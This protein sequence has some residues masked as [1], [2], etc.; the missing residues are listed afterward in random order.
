MTEVAVQEYRKLAI[1]ILSNA[2]PDEKEALGVWANQVLA[3][4]RSN[5]SRPIKAK[6]AILLTAR[7]NVIVPAL[8]IIAIEM[9]LDQFDASKIKFSSLDQ[10]LKSVRRF[11]D[12]R[13]LPA[14]LGI[15]ASTVALAL[16]GSQGAG[17]AALGTAIGVPLWVVFGAGAAF[18]GVLYEEVTGKKLDTTTTYKLID[19]KR[20]G[21][22]L[23]A[24]LWSKILGK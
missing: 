20:E 8:K 23:L 14:K 24:D 2:S 6:E 5:Y 3:I 18:A 22:N 11:W 4:K 16:F 7:S 13:S 17:I 15:G 12:D 1:R 21:G 19:A 10:V 9:K